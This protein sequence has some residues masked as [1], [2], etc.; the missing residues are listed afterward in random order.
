ME[1]INIK[2]YIKEYHKRVCVEVLEKTID[3]A[4]YLNF[5]NKT[6]DG[7]LLRQMH[8]TEFLHGML[9]KKLIPNALYQQLKRIAEDNTMEYEIVIK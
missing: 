6:R 7:S 2:E 5:P 8:G 1:T 4:R 9:K 3:Y